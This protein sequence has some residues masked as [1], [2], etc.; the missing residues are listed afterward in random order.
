MLK[1]PESRRATACLVLVFLGLWSS[2]F[3]NDDYSN[4]LSAYIDGEFELAQTHWLQAAEQDHYRAMFNLGLL[5]QQ[6][7]L[8]SSDPQKARRWYELAGRGGYA[9]ADFHHANWLLEERAEIEEVEKLLER[10]FANGYFPAGQ[11]LSSLRANGQLKPV[12]EATV[13]VQGTSLNN[14]LAL[15]YLDESWLSERNATAWTIQILAFAEL[16]KVKEFIDTH[17][18]H[19][20]AAFFTEKSGGA[21]LYKL[22]YGEFAN[23]EEADKARAELKPSL[24]EHGPWLRTIAS[25]Q[26]VINSQ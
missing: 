18:L 24:Q 16:T 2:V 7:K 11:K 5:H 13:A 23:K 4:G 20:R 10:S 15:S 25:V 22:V 12:R 8:L 17:R 21:T 3:A 6:G 19:D 26:D 9:A 14:D 1:K